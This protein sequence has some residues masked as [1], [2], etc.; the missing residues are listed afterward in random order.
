MGEAGAILV[1]TKEGSVSVRLEVVL[2]ISL[3]QREGRR[4]VEGGAKRERGALR[5][6]KA[7]SRLRDPGKSVARFVSPSSVPSDLLPTCTQEICAPGLGRIKPAKVRESG[8]TGTQTPRKGRSDRKRRHVNFN[9]EKKVRALVTWRWDVWRRPH[10]SRL[11]PQ[12]HVV[13]RRGVGRSGSAPRPCSFIVVAGGQKGDFEGLSDEV[14]RV[15][16]RHTTPRRRPARSG[17]ST[18]VAT[19]QRSLAWGRLLQTA[20]PTELVPHPHPPRKPRGPLGATAAL[21]L[22]TTV[23]LKFFDEACLVSVLKVTAPG[24]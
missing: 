5:D 12:P 14:P 7:V 3:V 18:G 1:K 13:R 17:A 11:H 20:R 2:L 23:R 6:L 10:K 15:G 8:L 24:P 4:G 21:R 22:H 9:T 16:L 19:C